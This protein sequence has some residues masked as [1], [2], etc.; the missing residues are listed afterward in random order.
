MRNDHK[1]RRVLLHFDQPTFTRIRGK[2][3]LL[4]LE[5]EQVISWDNFFLILF[6]YMYEDLQSTKSGG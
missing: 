2:K 6:D 4:E 3:N 5:S 1:I